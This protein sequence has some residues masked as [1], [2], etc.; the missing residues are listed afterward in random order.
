MPNDLTDLNA[1]PLPAVLEPTPLPASGTR[2]VAATDACAWLM[3]NAEILAAFKAEDAA[4]AE[5]HQAHVDA[6]MDADCCAHCGDFAPDLQR[7]KCGAC[8]AEEG[9]GEVF[10]FFEYLGR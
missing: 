7:G 4:I 1:A 2:A 6:W 8:R 5:L 10:G 9:P 3:S